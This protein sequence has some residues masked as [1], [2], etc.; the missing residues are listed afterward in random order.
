MIL[1]RKIYDKL[2]VEI[3][4]EDTSFDLDDDDSFFADIDGID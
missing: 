1:K 3:S 2:L 4:D